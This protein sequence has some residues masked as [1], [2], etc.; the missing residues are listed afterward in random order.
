MDGVG[1]E[2]AS[3]PRAAYPVSKRR[4]LTAA[5]YVSGVLSGDR[6]RKS[7]V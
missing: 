2:E 5:D 6:D 4:E 3:P 1:A 7:V